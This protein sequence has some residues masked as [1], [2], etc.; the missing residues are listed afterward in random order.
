[1]KYEPRSALAAGSDG[2]D[3]IRVVAADSLPLTAPNGALLLEHGATQQEAV[4]D[5]L[6]TQGWQGLR[7]VKDYAGLPRVTIA[8][9]TP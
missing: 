5:I 8:R 4:A 6:Q 1:M 2:L 3:A 9:R 7:C